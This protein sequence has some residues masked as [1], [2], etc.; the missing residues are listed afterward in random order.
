[1]GKT[2]SITTTATRS[3]FF[4]L[5]LRGLGEAPPDNFLGTSEVQ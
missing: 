2:I 4:R 5:W 3:S 1:M